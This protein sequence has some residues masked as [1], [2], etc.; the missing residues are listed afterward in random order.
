MGSQTLPRKSARAYLGA[1]QTALPGRASSYKMEKV[2]VKNKCNDIAETT[3]NEVIGDHCQAT[4]RRAEATDEDNFSFFG[5]V[6][7]GPA[8]LECLFGRGPI[9]DA[10]PLMKNDGPRFRFL[11]TRSDQLSRIR[12]TISLTSL[13][14]ILA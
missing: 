5:A 14:L 6:A 3:W 8:C 11:S 7:I 13:I 2:S 12:C 9:S 10:S 4:C 1:A